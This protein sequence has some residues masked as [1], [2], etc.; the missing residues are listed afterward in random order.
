MLPVSS[1]YGSGSGFPMQSRAYGRQLCS[2]RNLH[3]LD[4][5]SAWGWAGGLPKAE[6][7]PV[8]VWMLNAGCL[9]FTAASWEGSRPE[10]AD[11]L[12]KKDMA[13]NE[14]QGGGEGQWN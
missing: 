3:S 7:I 1:G 10:E 4:T 2:L 14:E 13:W 6:R 11:G 8:R 5:A 9:S 12:T